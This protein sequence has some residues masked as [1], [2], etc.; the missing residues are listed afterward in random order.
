MTHALMTPAM[1]ATSIMTIVGA[2]VGAGPG[3]G[4]GNTKTARGTTTVGTATM[5]GAHA[6]TT[7]GL[8]ANHATM[9]AAMMIDDIE[10]GFQKGLHASSS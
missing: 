10:L 3:A 8:V 1:R 2:A 5:T 4:A 7:E 6:T 9:S